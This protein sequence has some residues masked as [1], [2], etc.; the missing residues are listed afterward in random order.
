M[1]VRKF[2]ESES[3]VRLKHLIRS[4]ADIWTFSFDVHLH[5][6]Y[7]SLVSQHVR[8]RTT[9]SAKGI[10]TCGFITSGRLYT[11]RHFRN[12]RCQKPL[13]FSCSFSALSVVQTPTPISSSRQL[14]PLPGSN[15]HF[16]FIDHFTSLEIL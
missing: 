7:D 11:A 16:R 14:R 10:P 15:P 4:L 12:L 3:A 6:G 13:L 5:A 8:I 1:N 9:E 2:S